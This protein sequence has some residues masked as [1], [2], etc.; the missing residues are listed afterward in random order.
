MFLSLFPWLT[1]PRAIAEREEIN[2]F[3]LSAGFDIYKIEPGVL[4]YTTPR[5]ET[6]SLNFEGI[7]LDGDWR[8]SDLFLLRKVR[9]PDNA[10]VVKKSEHES[11]WDE[12]LIGNRRVKL[13]KREDNESQGFSFQNVDDGKILKSVS[14]RSSLRKN[15]DLW[16]SKNEAFSVNGIGLLQQALKFLEQGH[17]P[18]DVIKILKIGA[19]NPLKGIDKLSELLRELTIVD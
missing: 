9:N 18:D 11:E 5:F 16:T 15:I 1:R 6:A 2:Q 4:T 8:S 12:F 3:A 19:E 17:S 14:R 7:H 10:L 13:K